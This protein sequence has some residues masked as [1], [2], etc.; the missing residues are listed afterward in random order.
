MVSSSEARTENRIIP[1]HPAPPPSGRTSTFRPN[2]TA[3]Y[4]S[5]R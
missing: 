4:R 5:S 1:R 2:L 3:D